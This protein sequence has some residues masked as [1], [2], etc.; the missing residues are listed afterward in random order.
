MI[1]KANRAT[2]VLFVASVLML[3]LAAVLVS[4]PL[5][6][7]AAQQDDD[8]PKDMQ[9][10]CVFLAE[11]DEDLEIGI[12]WTNGNTNSPI[13][14]AYDNFSPEEIYWCGADFMCF[15]RPFDNDPGDFCLSYAAIHN[16]WFPNGVFGE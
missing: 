15:D 8:G 11:Q 7:A 10:L 2:L 3:V 1:A 6:R 5:S 16:F 12:G 4:Q 13:G 9:E 14:F